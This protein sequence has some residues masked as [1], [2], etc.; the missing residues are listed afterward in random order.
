MFL[1]K[2]ITVCIIIC[3]E[4]V[5]FSQQ[6]QTGVLFDFDTKI[7]KSYDLS[8]TINFN[9]SCI[10][11]SEININDIQIGDVNSVLE[12]LEFFTKDRENAQDCIPVVIEYDENLI[13][14]SASDEVYS[15]Q[16][17]AQEIKIKA[18]AFPGVIRALIYFD[19]L[20]LKVDRNLFEFHVLDYP[21]INKRY[22]HLTQIGKKGVLKVNELIDLAAK[23]KFNGV[24]LKITR[25]VYF[26]TFGDSKLKDSIITKESLTEIIKYCRTKGFEVILEFKL[27]TH[28]DRFYLNNEYLINK[29]TY[30]TQNPEVYTQLLS[31]F[32]EVK[33]DLNVDG[34]HIGHDELYGYR[35]YHKKLDNI[36][37]EEY[38][39]EDIIKLRSLILDLDLTLLMWGDMFLSTDRFSRMYN[40]SLHGNDKLEQLLDS[41]PKDIIINTFHY[42]DVDFYD[43]LSFLDSK[44]FQTSGGTWCFSKNIIN[45]TNYMLTNF[46]FDKRMMVATTWYGAINHRRA[47]IIQK[48]C[49]LLK[50]EDIINFT[51]KTFW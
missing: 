48:G 13:N 40:K 16:V 50:I 42:W 33:Y 2:L 10:S 35:S 49:D 34:I 47:K 25:D 32:K 5:S 20:M 21:L 39:L 46:S 43:S 6:Q 14:Y 23:N 26:E 31:L 4:N 28:Q 12:T 41:L 24:I 11:F 37:S 30:D 19:N 8:K 44:G 45:Q 18:V 29:E 15:I 27:L 17:T 22:I 9:K 36:L 7:V 1:K 3:F 51:G 38:F